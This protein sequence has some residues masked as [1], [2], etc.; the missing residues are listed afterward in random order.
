MDCTTASSE[1]TSGRG[2]S[3][4]FGG[5]AHQEGELPMN[6]VNR[7]KFAQG[8]LVCGAALAVPVLTNGCSAAS[9][10]QNTLCCKEYQA[11]TDMSNV[12]FGVKADV[13]GQFY[14]FAQ[15]S[16]DLTVVA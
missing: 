4:G 13:A 5:L 11:G 10:I 15:A 14:A 9:S 12:N 6:G 2:S 7:L 3:C 1:G 16:G 8:L